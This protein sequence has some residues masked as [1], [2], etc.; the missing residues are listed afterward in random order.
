MAEIRDISSL[1]P[2][3]RLN[4]LSHTK[5]KS[6]GFDLLLKETIGKLQEIQN[7]AERAVKELVSGGDIIQAMLAMQ[8]AE[9]SFQLMIEVRNRLLNAYEEIQRMQI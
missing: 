8:K 4:R 2:Q 3:E 7:D 6:E 9:L 1:K 5:N